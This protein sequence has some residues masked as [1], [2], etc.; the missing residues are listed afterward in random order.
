MNIASLGKQVVSVFP[1]NAQRGLLII[2]A[3][4][5][6]LGGGTLTAIRTGGASGA[7]TN[8]LARSDS[9]LVAIF[10]AGVQSCTQLEAVCIVRPTQSA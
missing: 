3:T 9:Q 5:L 6:V 10:G 8:P 4:V 7:A 1:H 2:H